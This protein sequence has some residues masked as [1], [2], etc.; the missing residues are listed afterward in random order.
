MKT[1]IVVETKNWSDMEKVIAGINNIVNVNAN[2]IDMEIIDWV[3]NEEVSVS[4][5]RSPNN[6][7]TGE[8]E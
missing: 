3:G 2:V 6:E 5:Y 4:G 7:N 8:T 1:R